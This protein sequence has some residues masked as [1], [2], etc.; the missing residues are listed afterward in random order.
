MDG[1]ANAE[2]HIRYIKSFFDLEM[3]EVDSISD[4]GFG[5][6][7]MFQEALKIF[8]PVHAY[9][10]EPSKPAYQEVVRRNLQKKFKGKLTLKNVDLHTWC[11]Q[12][13]KTEPHASLGFCTSVFQY[14]SENEIDDIL[15]VLAR[16]VKYLYFSVPTNIELKRQVAEL[17]YKDIYAQKRSKVWYQK[18]IRPHFTF[19]SNR[20]LESRHFYDEKNTPLGELLFRY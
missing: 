2:E 12:N 16:R 6:G 8:Q 13:F 17:G 19:V 3:I 9:G 5:L 18:K 7:Y 1:V 11:L 20:L 14:L 4:L 10:I 15:P